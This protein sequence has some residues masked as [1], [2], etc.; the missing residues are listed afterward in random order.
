MARTRQQAQIGA[1][2]DNERKRTVTPQTLAPRNHK[3]FCCGSSSYTMGRQRNAQNECFTQVVFADYP[4]VD[5]I[6]NITVT[7]TLGT[8]FVFLAQ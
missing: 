6:K 4:L 3:L 8:H 5:S 2:I 1:P 7:S